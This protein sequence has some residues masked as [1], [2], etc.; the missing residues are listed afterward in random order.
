[1]PPCVIGSPAQH[2]R[3]K[4]HTGP[5]SRDGPAA[6]ST[7]SLSPSLSVSSHHALSATASPTRT[8]VNTRH[9]TPHRRTRQAQCRR[10]LSPRETPAPAQRC[11]VLCTPRV[12]GAHTPHVRHRLSLSSAGRYGKCTSS[13]G[14]SSPRPEPGIPPTLWAGTTVHQVVQ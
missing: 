7:P 3:R 2:K 1:M 5:P 11:I 6:P 12:A 10:D 4:A 13:T 8:I 14:R 9:D